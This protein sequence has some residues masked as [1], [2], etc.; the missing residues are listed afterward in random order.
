MSLRL[1]TH[2]GESHSWGDPVCK[3]TA[4][5]LVCNCA[6]DRRPSNAWD[7]SQPHWC[8][9]RSMFAE[10]SLCV[11][12]R[13][14][15]RSPVIEGFLKNFGFCEGR[16]NLKVPS[17]SS[18]RSGWAVEMRKPPLFTQKRAPWACSR[19]CCRHTVVIPFPV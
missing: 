8:P 12:F 3:S 5:V 16:D 2:V 11:T 7:P 13:K 9:L 18:L 19:W 14:G 4:Y 15:I 10:R 1:F 17:S 6:G